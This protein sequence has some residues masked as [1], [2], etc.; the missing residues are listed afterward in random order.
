MVS[1]TA[2]PKHW[3]ENYRRQQCLSVTLH[4]DLQHDAVARCPPAPRLG[5]HH[6]SA[7]V[8]MLPILAP[9]PLV[10]Q[11]PCRSSDQ[12]AQSPSA[13]GQVTLALLNGGPKATHITFIT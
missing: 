2:A 7:R 10:T 9:C 8:S 12:L 5:L 13:R 11:Q 4:A 3:M 6:P 1:S